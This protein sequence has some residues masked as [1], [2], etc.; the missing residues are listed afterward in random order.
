MRRFGFDAAILFSGYF[1]CSAGA[2]PGIEFQLTAKGPSLAAA[3]MPH[4]CRF[5]GR[6]S[7]QRAGAD[8]R[9]VRRTLKSA[10]RRQDHAARILRCAVDSRDL[11]DGRRGTPDQAPARLFACRDP[12]RSRRLMDRF[13]CK[14]SIE[15]L[16]GQISAGAE[17][18]QIF[19]TWAGVLDRNSLIVG[20]SS[21]RRKSSKAS[22]G[23]YQMPRSLDFRVV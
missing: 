2:G 10:L 22:V 9:N 23:R 7:T 12:E 3:R 19:D 16:V 6:P 8:L 4:R 13:W 15:Y 17:V 20:V 5:A 21:Q 1:D 11:H 18:V 14:R